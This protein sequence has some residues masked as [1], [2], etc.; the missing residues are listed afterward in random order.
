MPRHWQQVMDITGRCRSPFGR[1]GEGS[2]VAQTREFQGPTGSWWFSYAA[3]WGDA[4]AT[5]A[6]G[7][8]VRRQPAFF[9]SPKIPEVFAVLFWS[10]TCLALRAVWQPAIEVAGFQ[11]RARLA[12][13]SNQKTFRLVWS[14]EACMT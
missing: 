10:H 8:D 11:V 4:T 6:D 3:L 13:P 7:S 5:S 1:G 9:S 2:E 14:L 12:V